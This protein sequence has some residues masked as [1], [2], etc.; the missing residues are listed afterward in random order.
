MAR[1]KQP[2]IGAADKRTIGALLRELRRG[3]GY[4]SVDKAA[5]VPACPASIATIYA[6]ERGGL[7]PSLAQFLEL[8]EFYVLETPPMATG[9]KPEG[10]L[11]TMGVA[12]VTRA[13]T[14]PAYHVAQANDLV[15]RMQPDL[16]D[17]P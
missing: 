11:R 14:L 7:V 6:Y 3:A 4:R 2:P 16:G 12:A 15:A 13:L 10:D 9:A 5:E 1:K 8:V 17:H